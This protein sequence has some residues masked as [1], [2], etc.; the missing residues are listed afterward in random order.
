MDHGPIYVKHKTME[1]LKD[2]IRENTGDSGLGN[3]FPDT[4]AKAEPIKEI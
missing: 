4:T 2:N 1:L 3:E